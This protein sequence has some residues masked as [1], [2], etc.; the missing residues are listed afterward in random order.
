MIAAALSTQHAGPIPLL[1][2]IPDNQVEQSGVLGI[3]SLAGWVA[4]PWINDLLPTLC[5]GS[6]TG[7]H[8]APKQEM[9]LIKASLAELENH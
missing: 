4:L 6:G 5:W 9:S 1:P 7:P 2:S 3:F 8:S